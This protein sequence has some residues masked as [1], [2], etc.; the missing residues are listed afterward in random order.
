MKIRISVVIPVYNAEAFLAEAIG[1]VLAQ[2]RPDLEIIVVDDGSTDRSLEVARSFKAV[3]C[4]H[5]ANGGPAAARNAGIE[6]ASG[7][8]YAFLDADDVWTEDHLQALLPFIEQDGYDMVF[9]KMQKTGRAIK[10]ADGQ[11]DLL[12]SSF[13]AF[14]FGSSLIRSEAFHRV[15]WLDPSFR[16]AEDTEWC[17]R[18][19]EKGLKIHLSDR[20]V[21]Y[22]R[23]H[24]NN[25]SRGDRGP[26]DR[27]TLRI[28]RESLDRR[29]RGEASS[30]TPLDLA[31]S[32]REEL[33]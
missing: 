7:S 13:G 4:L 31:P 27:V 20:V 29:R 18:A 14:G 2:G 17:T 16:R 28:I 30:L 11:L 10:R 19:K 33:P 24:Q 12:G 1:S 21:L 3:R 6:A 23:Q 8:I 22:Y 32:I 9:G 5:R 26:L 15:G 25:L